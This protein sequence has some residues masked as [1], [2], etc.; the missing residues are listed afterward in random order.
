MFS[1]FI[2]LPSPTLFF[3]FSFRSNPPINLLPFFH[4]ILHLHPCTPITFY[5]LYFYLHQSYNL[6]ILFSMFLFLIKPYPFSFCTNLLPPSTTYFIH[7]NQP[8]HP[9]INSLLPLQSLAKSAEDK[10][11]TYDEEKDSNLVREDEGIRDDN[12]EMVF[13]AGQS[14][15]V[16]GELYKV[17]FSPPSSNIL[18][19]RK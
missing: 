8:I 7:T 15:R 5:F 2:H 6:L 19:L 3:C 13:K 14:K 1:L 4:S 16:W 12:P 18:H 17:S 9:P 10:E 11:Q